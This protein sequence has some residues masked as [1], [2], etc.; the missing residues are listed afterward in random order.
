MQKNTR[1]AEYAAWAGKGFRV[2]KESVQALGESL[3]SDLCYQTSVVNI[4]YSVIVLWLISTLNSY[5]LLG[6][7]YDFLLL[8]IGYKLALY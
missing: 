5:K 4:K 6:G 1:G 3:C 2:Q 8:L 7:F